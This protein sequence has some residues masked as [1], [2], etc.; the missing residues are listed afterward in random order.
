MPDILRELREAGPMPTV[1]PLRFGSIVELVKQ[2]AASR[3][4]KSFSL[5]QP[6]S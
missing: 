4:V 2:A 3:T 5:S 6:P 1:D